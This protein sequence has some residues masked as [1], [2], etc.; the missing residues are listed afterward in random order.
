MNVTIMLESYN[1]G[2]RFLR[3]Y[4]V[5]MDEAIRCFRLSISEYE[6]LYEESASNR[7]IIDSSGGF[8]RLYRECHYMLH[9]LFQRKFRNSNR[10]DK[11]GQRYAIYSTAHK[12]LASFY[13]LQS[14]KQIPWHCGVSFDVVSERLVDT[15]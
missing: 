9:V 4:N 10:V 8:E 2:C 6:T 1:K 5:D 11:L 15:A 7:N 12:Q 14:F 13:G 3:D